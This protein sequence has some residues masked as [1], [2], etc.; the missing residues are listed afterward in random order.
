MAGKC[1]RSF[2]IT[3]INRIVKRKQAASTGLLMPQ[4]YTGLFNKLVPAC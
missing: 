1:C 4:N 2:Y 3:C